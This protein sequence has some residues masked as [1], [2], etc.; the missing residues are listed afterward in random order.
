MG[1]M[2]K[3]VPLNLEQIVERMAWKLCSMENEV[4]DEA[5]QSYRDRWRRE[6]AQLLVSRHELFLTIGATNV[7]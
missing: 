1:E 5:P 4:W 3:D 7:Q 6:A 2:T